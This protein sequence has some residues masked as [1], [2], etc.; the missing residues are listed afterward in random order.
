MNTDINIV[1][2]DDHPLLRNGVVRTL[3]A[4]QGLNVLGEADDAESAIKT[5]AACHPDLVLLDISMPG[6]GIQAAEEISKLPSAPKIVML[7]VSEN[8]DDVIDSLKA[9]A[10][11][12]VLKGVKAD[13]LISVVESVYA[14]DTF[15]P[16]SLATQVLMETNNPS[17][18]AKSFGKL[19]Q[20]LSERELEILNLVSEGLSNK[21]VGMALELQEKTVKHHMTSIMAKLHVR[22]RVEAAVQASKHLN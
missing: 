6:G 14:G 18:K 4:R 3:Q 12:Y 8:E 20:E 1:V 17:S 9:G 10:Q 7:T 11:G 22:N 5:C 21:E 15:I 19:L 13:E 16:P 2:A